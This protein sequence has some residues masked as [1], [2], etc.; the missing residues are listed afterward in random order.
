MAVNCALIALG[1]QTFLCIT[2]YDSVGLYQLA[3]RLNTLNWQLCL[4]YSS[5][6]DKIPA[7]VD[8]YGASTTIV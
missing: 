1:K 4:L 5:V 7:R 6:L 8:P 3:I 2:I